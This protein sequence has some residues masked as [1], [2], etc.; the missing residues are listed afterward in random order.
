M[1]IVKFRIS[2]AFVVFAFTAAPVS[3]SYIWVEGFGQ[4][5]NYDLAYADAVAMGE[6]DCVD[7]G[8]NPTI[9]TVYDAIHYPTFWWVNTLTRCNLP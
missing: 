3:A 8:G 2:L 9:S 6:S 1:N 4:N 7:F 5:A